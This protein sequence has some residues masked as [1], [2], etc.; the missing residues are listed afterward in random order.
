MSAQN[1]LVRAPDRVRYCACFSAGLPLVESFHLSRVYFSRVWCLWGHSWRPNTSAAAQ[2]RLLSQ[3][4]LAALQTILTASS[5]R[6]SD[7]TEWKSWILLSNRSITCGVCANMSNIP[8]IGPVELNITLARATKTSAFLHA[9]TEMTRNNERNNRYLHWELLYLLVDKIVCAV[10]PLWFGWTPSLHSQPT[11]IR[12]G[13]SQFV[14]AAKW[15][16]IT[17]PLAT[18]CLFDSTNWTDLI[19]DGEWVVWVSPSLFNLETF[20]VVEQKF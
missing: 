1:L 2:W 7:S 4:L 11:M 14:Q 3:L 20:R 16:R 13:S 10:C 17:I 19:L 8:L 5:L 9:T 12:S 15:R 6:I 18:R